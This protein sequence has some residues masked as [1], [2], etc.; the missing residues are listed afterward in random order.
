MNDQTY[1]RGVLATLES[2]NVHGDTRA[3]RQLADLI[4]GTRE[5]LVAI[6]AP[7]APS[8]QAPPSH[9]RAG[10]VV[11][12]ERVPVPPS[13]PR[14]PVLCESNQSDDI[15]TAE[16]IAPFSNGADESTATEGAE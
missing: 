3:M 16:D 5:R 11:D 15:A 10:L 4:D 2:L 14:P 8:N 13:R 6:R 9:P 1:F 7:I 12:A